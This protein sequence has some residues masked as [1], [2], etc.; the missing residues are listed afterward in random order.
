MDN[1]LINHFR[2]PLNAGK[3]ADAAGEGE[4]GDLGCGAVI[5]IY[6]SFKDERI[7]AAGFE[8]TGSSAAI[9]AGSLMTCLVK[10]KHWRQ[11]AAISLADMESEMGIGADEVEIGIGAGNISQTPVSGQNLKRA[12]VLNAANFAID[13]LHAAFEDAIKRGTFPR[14][15]LTR[16]GST[17]VAMSGGV[18]SSVA[19]LLLKEAGGEVLGLTMRLWSDPECGATGPG[20]CSPQSIRDARQVCHVLGVPHLTVDLQDEFKALV[21]D[22]FVRE[23]MDGRTPNP[24]C[25]CNG[26]FRFAALAALADRLGAERVATGHYVKRE[27]KNIREF[28]FRGKDP[29]KDQ[30]YMMWGIA[31]EILP[32]L[33]F[34][35]GGITKEQTRQLAAGAALVTRSRPESQEVCFIPDDDYRRFLRSQKGRLPGEGEITDAGGRR[36]GTH[37]GYIDYTVGQRRGLGISAPEPLYVIGTVPAENRVIAG[38]RDSLSVDLLEICEVN[39]FDAGALNGELSL[40][41]RY[42]A[43]PVKAQIIDQREDKWAIALN[44]P[45]YGIASGQSAVLYEGDK[46]VAGGIICRAGK[47][48]LS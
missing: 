36:L 12:S 24:C 16:P 10:G 23:Y 20:C 19:C 30:S 28:L 42:N 43:A 4:A 8:A 37:S 5:R 44:E 34:P 25:R 18:D 14:A 13:A 32:R 47:N 31:P 39:I 1:P 2:H 46:L 21:V 3:L 7:A 11:A 27:F 6:I 15:A 26:S 48:R 38:S 17:L 29:G 40:Q 33:D 9:A 45:V 35:L 22:D 41:V